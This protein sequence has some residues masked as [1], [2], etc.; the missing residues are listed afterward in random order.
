MKCAFLFVCPNTGVLTLD[1]TTKE[2]R[3]AVTKDLP[4]DV[5]YRITSGN[6]R[7]NGVNCL[8][9]HTLYKNGKYTRV[10][11]PWTQA[12]S[13]SVTGVNLDSSTLHATSN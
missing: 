2:Y 9:V 4:S 6:V 3:D 8:H 7:V 11:V 1:Y 12:I 13:L 5:K 10:P